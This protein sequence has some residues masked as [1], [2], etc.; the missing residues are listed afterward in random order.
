MSLQNA[1]PSPPP[2]PL[3]VAKSQVEKHLM[4]STAEIHGFLG[5]ESWEAPILVTECDLEARPGYQTKKAHEYLDTEAVLAQKVKLL[6]QLIQKSK[7]MITYT[8]AGLSTA[9]GINDYATKA[10]AQSVAHTAAKLT[11]PLEALPSF[12]HY[13]LAALHKAGYLKHWI[14][15]NHDGLPQKA[16]YPQHDINEIHG[17]WFDPSNPVVPMS[18]QL[19]GDLFSWME[20]WELRTDLCLTLG[21]SLCGMNADR[22]AVSPAKRALK[23]KEGA[24]GTVIVGLQCTQFDNLSSIR[25]FRQDRRCDEA[26][27]QRA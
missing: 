24:L 12:G 3:K 19:R 15:Q 21:T 9:A 4:G 23:K 13:A 17:A 18:G 22:M 14:Q 10:G 6:A 2:L 8:G 25:I 20:K 27:S 26:P 16:G 5:S 11:S 1:I 7:N